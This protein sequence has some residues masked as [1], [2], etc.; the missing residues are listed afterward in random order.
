MP[1]VRP[2]ESLEPEISCRI[3]FS[4]IFACGERKG[5]RDVGVPCAYFMKNDEEGV[6]PTGAER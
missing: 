1:L 5:M 4:V 2:V 3:V 6:E